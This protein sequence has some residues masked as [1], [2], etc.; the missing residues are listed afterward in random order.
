MIVLS[1]DKN[2]QNKTYYDTNGVTSAFWE[3]KAFNVFSRELNMA[4][5]LKCFGRKNEIEL[6]GTEYKAL[7]RTT[8]RAIETVVTITLGST[9]EAVNN[10][11]SKWQTVTK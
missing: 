1:Y 7:T 9:K 3:L 10:E 5:Q 4:P 2:Q 11:L 8:I 6:I